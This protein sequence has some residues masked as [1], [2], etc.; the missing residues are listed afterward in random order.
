MNTRG[1]EGGCEYTRLGS[2]MLI[3]EV[4]KEDVNSYIQTPDSFTPSDKKG[5][6]GLMLVVKN[7]N[8][9]MAKM[10]LK[11]KAGVCVCVCVCSGGGGMAAT[12][13]LTLFSPNRF[14]LTYPST[15]CPA[16]SHKVTNTTVTQDL[17]WLGIPYA[18]HHLHRS[19]CN[20]VWH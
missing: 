2:W 3:H 4:G 16:K 5:C 11:C 8:L 18:R 12:N 17:S 7:D 13:A 10:L 15:Q 20:F 6:T 1:W 19:N 14:S 9:C